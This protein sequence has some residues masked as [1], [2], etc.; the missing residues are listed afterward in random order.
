MQLSATLK[1]IESM[2]RIYTCCKWAQNE[3]QNKSEIPKN[4]KMVLHQV[5][6]L[7]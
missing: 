2:K 6:F 7:M 5:V 4:W 3:P 1:T